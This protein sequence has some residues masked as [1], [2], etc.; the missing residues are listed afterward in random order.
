MT[1]IPFLGAFD[2]E[3]PLS[4]EAPLGDGEW[5]RP[6]EPV[7]AVVAIYEAAPRP[8][9][10]T[11]LPTHPGLW[12]VRMPG[13]SARVVEVTKTESGSLWFGWTDIPRCLLTQDLK[14]QGFQW[15]DRAIV[16]P[17]EQ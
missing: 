17:V 14:H 8:R 4:D 12:F 15:G 3:H 2:V 10:T 16:E 9:W 13:L 6:P 5:E 11:D 1:H 7:S